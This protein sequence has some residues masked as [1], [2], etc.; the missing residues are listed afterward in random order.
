MT[1]SSL[2]NNNAV[3]HMSKLKTW[4]F[5]ATLTDTYLS[6]YAILTHILKDNSSQEIFQWYIK[7]WTKL[8]D[9]VDLEVAESDAYEPHLKLMASETA[10]RGKQTV[11]E[12]PWVLLH[13]N[14]VMMCTVFEGFLLNVLDCILMTESKVL[15]SLALEKQVSLEKVIKSKDKEQ[16]LQDFREKVKNHFSRQGIKEKY[17]I[18]EKIGIKPEEVFDFSVFKP[19]PWQVASTHDLKRLIKIFD[20]RHDV[21]HKRILPIRNPEELYDIYLFFSGIMLRLTSIAVGKFN[22]TSDLPDYLR[23]GELK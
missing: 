20:Q 5:L 3:V 12:I 4:Q 17:G 18:F 16:L 2:S 21:V 22:V 13:Q 1:T 19:L 7:G 14:L 8:T 10:K 15:L 23:L 9:L 11:N 6:T